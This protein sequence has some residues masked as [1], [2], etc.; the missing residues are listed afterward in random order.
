[1]VAP[2]MREGKIGGGLLVS[3]TQFDYFTPFLQQVVESYA[4]LLALAF[5]SEAFYEPAHISLRIVPPQSVQRPYLARFSHRLTEILRLAGKDQRS[6][7]LPQAEQLVWQQFEELFFDL[8]L[9]EAGS[10]SRLSSQ[11]TWKE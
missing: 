11:P 4:D 1:M 10:E 6:L 7:G 5:G 2:I 3:S 9:A 8:S